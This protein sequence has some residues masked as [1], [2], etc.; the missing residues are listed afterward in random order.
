MVLWGCIAQ[1]LHKVILVGQHH[2]TVMWLERTEGNEVRNSLQPIFFFFFSK[3][4]DGPRDLLFETV[5]RYV[6]RQRKREAQTC[7]CKIFSAALA[8][9][10]AAGGIFWHVINSYFYSR[11]LI[12][13]HNFKFVMKLIFILI[14]E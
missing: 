3:I 10:R 7:L 5:N 6:I 12:N 8:R 14:W 2:L 13:K 1:S 4:W 9:I 11:N